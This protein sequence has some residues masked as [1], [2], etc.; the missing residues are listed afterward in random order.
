MKT[1]ISF[2]FF[3]FSL[4][5]FNSCTP[6]EINTDNNQ[7]LVIEN[8]AMSV[9]PGQ[10]ITYTAALIDISG[11]KTTASNVTWSSVN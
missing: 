3:T 8:G 1:Y 10:N 4:L 11:T 2:L 5:F 7:L 6:E 9:E